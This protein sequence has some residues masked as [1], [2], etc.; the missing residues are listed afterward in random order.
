MRPAGQARHRRLSQPPVVVACHHNQA[1]HVHVTI[2]QVPGEALG[3]TRRRPA[4]LSQRLVHAQPPLRLHHAERVQDSLPRSRLTIACDDQQRCRR[5]CRADTQLSV[6]RRSHYRLRRRELGQVVS[7][8]GLAGGGSR[9]VQP[10]PQPIVQ[11]HRAGTAEPATS[12]GQPPDWT[13]AYVRLPG[14]AGPYPALLADPLTPDGPL[15]DDHL[16]ARVTADA[17]TRTAADHAER[18]GPDQETSVPTVRLVGDTAEIRHPDNAAGP[19]QVIHPDADGLYLLT[20]WPW[21]PAEPAGP[22][23]AANAQ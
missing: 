15:A 10:P 13:P 8:A 23:R 3:P 21:Q 9:T 6:A 4:P 20:G 19:T 22:A 17:I 5:L 18:G 12:P 1:Q 14:L 11:H 2:G 7:L 16:W